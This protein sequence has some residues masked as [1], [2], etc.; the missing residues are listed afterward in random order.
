[1][2]KRDEVIPIFVNLTLPMLL[3]EE[4]LIFYINALNYF[5]YLHICFKIN[6]YFYKKNEGIF[7]KMRPKKDEELDFQNW[8]LNDPFNQ[9]TQ[10]SSSCNTA[11]LMVLFFSM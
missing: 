2:V 1:M 10:I 7:V 4:Y 8:V 11:S 3:F 9:K 5:K 6:S